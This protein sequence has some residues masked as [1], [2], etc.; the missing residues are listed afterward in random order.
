MNMNNNNVAIAVVVPVF[1][2]AKTLPVLEKRLDSV[3][4]QH[5][6]NYELI[7][8]DDFSSDDSWVTIRELASKNPCIKG[9]KLAQNYG[10]WSA[11]LLGISKT[12]A[13]LIVTI[14]DDLEYQPEDIIHLY[15]S[16]KNQPHEIVFGIAEN[17]YVAQGKNS[18]LAH[19]RNWLLNRLWNKPKT[20][21]FKIFYRDLVFRNDIFNINEHFESYLKRNLQKQKWGYTTV[22]YKV[23]LSG[24]SNYSLLKKIKLF[25]V[26]SLQ[27]LIQKKTPLHWL[28][29]EET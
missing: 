24:K 9:L 7:L 6:L 15:H 8:V 13:N 18:T 28:I 26:F 19:T 22:N 16:I 5:Q 17:K 14:D 23:R 2:S 27:Y 3:L 29:A 25:L 12:Q 11:T 1:N 4:T 10:Q 21:S 20:D